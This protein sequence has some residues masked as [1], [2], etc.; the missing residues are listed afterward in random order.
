[1]KSVLISFTALLLLISENIYSQYVF[2]NGADLCSYSKS[3]S[4]KLYMP[5]ISDNAPMHKFDVLDYKLYLDIYNC[6]RSP[7]PKSYNANI[8]VKFRVDTALSSIQLNAVNRSLTIDSVRNAG[9]SFAHSSNVLT[10]NLN[11]TYSPGEIADVKIFY[12][13]NNVYDSAFYVSSGFVFTF[14]EPEGA[15]NWYPCWDKPGDK[16]TFDITTKVPIEVKLGSNGRLQDSTIT[17]DTIYYHWISRDP[18]ATYLAVISAKVYFNLDIVYWHKISNPLD[19]IPI[20]FYWNYG[21]NIDSLENCKAKIIPMTT[22]YSQLFGEHPFEKN[23][24]ASVKG[25]S[26]FSGG[27]EHQTLTSSINI[28]EWNEGLISHE[29]AHQ[30]FGD[31]ITCGTWADIWLNEGFATYCDA[32]WFGRNSQSVYKS[33]ILSYADTYKAYNPQTPIYNQSWANSTPPFWV[34]FN[35]ATT[36]GK[37]ACVLHMLRYTIGD[38]LFFAS[39]KSYATDTAYKYKNAVTSDFTAKVN[40]IAGQNYDWFFDQ[41]IYKPN[42]PKYQNTYGIIQ[43]DTLHWKVQFTVK[44]VQSNPVFFKM[45]VE[46][47]IYLSGPDTVIKVMNDF[48]NQLFEFTFDRLPQA[49]IFDPNNDIVLKEAT[50]TIGIENTSSR[51]PQKYCLFQNYPNPFNSSTLIKFDIAK[52]GH[53]KIILYDIQGRKMEMLVNQNLEA[54]SYKISFDAARLSSGIYFVKIESGYFVDSKKLVLLK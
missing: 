26:Y 14:C 35:W 4:G 7:Y 54:G 53:T 39:L 12:R 2:K 31:L 3:R 22:Y 30:W 48:N 13:H 27:M 47:K 15:R 52:I 51:I 23:G 21:E 28:G 42:H 19:S 29:F 50:T 34:L 24:F 41:W 20:R 44:Q 33:T 43:I 18:M 32:L 40:Q 5:V 16:A 11:R 45:P 10:V 6:F 49:L 38:S 37:G 17:G 8:V 9:V 46:V 1:M 36:Y 25:Q